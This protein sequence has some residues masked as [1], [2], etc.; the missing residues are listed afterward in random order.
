MIVSLLAVMPVVVQHE[1]ALI[2]FVISVVS[3][4]TFAKSL[5]ETLLGEHFLWA[6]SPDEPVGKQHHRITVPG[7]VKVVCGDDHYHSLTRIIFDH[8]KD[9]VLAWDVQSCYWLIQ[10]E[11]FG[12]GGQHLGNPHPLLLSTAEFAETVIQKVVDVEALAGG[13]HG[14]S[15]SG[16]EPAGE[17]PLAISA[18]C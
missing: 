16:L 17:A 18:H 2:V 9:P 1:H 10:Q 13:V 3:Q 11:H 14:C 6:A 4:E 8:R 15:V 12:F 5:P 7:F